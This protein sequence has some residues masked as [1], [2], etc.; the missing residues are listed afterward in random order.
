MV[1]SRCFLLIQCFPEDE[2]SSDPI[3]S[4]TR[5]YLLPCFFL[6]D[7]SHK[8]LSRVLKA[9][10]SLIDCNRHT[11]D[12]SSIVG[13]VVSVLLSMHKDVKIWKNICL[14]KAD[15][16]SILQNIVC[17]QVW[18]LD[19]NIVFRNFLFIFSFICLSK[20]CPRYLRPYYNS[21]YS[22]HSFICCSTTFFMQC[23][24]EISLTL[25]EKY[26]IR[27]AADHLKN[28]TGKM[29]GKVQRES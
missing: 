25:E 3:H 15:I 9:L 14:F 21:K 17:L 5:Y 7:R 23:S 2:A 27:C 10:G 8:L 22:K 13:S 6:F 1:I 26:K 12:H 4:R 16:D 28:L 18:F 20:A 24:E 19:H 11:T 29:D